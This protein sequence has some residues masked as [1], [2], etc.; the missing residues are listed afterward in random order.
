VFGIGGWELFV[1]ALV[2]LLVLGP[3]GLPSAAR[4]V[5]RLFSE[6]RRATSDLRES[7]ELDPELRELPRALDELN[8]PLLSPGPYPRRRTPRDQPTAS[9]GP[10][11]EAAAPPAAHEVRAPGARA[12]EP[13]RAAEPGGGAQDPGEGPGEGASPGSGPEPGPG[14]TPAERG[15]GAARGEGG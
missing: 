14:A 9:P 4:A 5:G 12:A 6:V 3:K 8:R 10:D 13:E 1:I 7:I 2:A 11:T 15:P